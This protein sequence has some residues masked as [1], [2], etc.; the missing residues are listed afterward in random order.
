[1]THRR[2]VSGCATVPGFVDTFPRFLW[3]VLLV[4]YL[5]DIHASGGAEGFT[6]ACARFTFT[7]TQPTSQH[8]RTEATSTMAP[9]RPPVTPSRS[10]CPSSPCHSTTSSLYENL[11]LYT[12]ELKA[13]RLPSPAT[14]N[15]K[16]KPRG[17][18]Q[19]PPSPASSSASHPVGDDRMF[20]KGLTSP[21]SP[22]RASRPGNVAAAQ[23]NPYSGDDLRQHVPECDSTLGDGLPRTASHPPPPPPTK[24]SRRSS[25]PTPHSDTPPRGDLQ[26]PP[27]RT[28]PPH[29]TVPLHFHRALRR[30]DAT[31][32]LSRHP[33]CIQTARR[34]GQRWGHGGCSCPLPSLALTIPPGL[35]FRFAAAAPAVVVG[36]VHR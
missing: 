4:P 30:R 31:E 23:A 25:S 12:E 11:K 26:Q 16:T 20:T 21:V 29:L 10:P 18:L 7:R 35:P 13:S 14:P 2:V 3:H 19:M 22:P 34:A 24:S 9:R 8:E 5:A 27:P 17:D 28:S 6:D 36:S 1:M 32:R 15:S 33:R